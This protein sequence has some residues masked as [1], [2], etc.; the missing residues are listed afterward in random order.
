MVTIER[1]TTTIGQTMLLIE[2]GPRATS[3][4]ILN[5]I[6]HATPTPHNIENSKQ[7]KNL[8]HINHSL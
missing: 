8:S 2:P 1:E 6:L 3:N 5:A 4:V 7:D